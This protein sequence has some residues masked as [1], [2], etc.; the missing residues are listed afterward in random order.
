MSTNHYNRSIANRSALYVALF[1]VA[2]L[3]YLSRSIIAAP[4]DPVIA[5]FPHSYLHLSKSTNPVIALSYTLTS[6]TFQSDK[7]ATKTNIS[8]SSNYVIW[9]EDA[10]LVSRFR[11]APETNAQPTVS[12]VGVCS[13]Q[14]W[15]LNAKTQLVWNTK[16]DSKI[17]AR[18]SASEISMR[19]LAED[20]AVR[21]LH[22]GIPLIPLGSVSIEGKNL[23]ATNREGKIWSGQM[24][25]DGSNAIH[26]VLNWRGSS[27]FAIQSA[28]FFSSLTNLLPAR[29]VATLIVSENA[30]ERKTW[31]DIQFKLLNEP[32]PQAAFSPSTLISGK[33]DTY[34]RSGNKVSYI[35]NKNKLVPVTR[36]T[37]EG[38]G[39][40][41]PLMLAA[42]FIT[43]FL[44]LRGYMSFKKSSKEKAYHQ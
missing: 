38:P 34:I 39:W 18:K 41:R 17:S 37:G 35:S 36:S 29:C 23:V 31:S 11:P 44:F 21:L 8:S 7:G 1:A 2:S 10:F 42:I 40:G 27:A 4:S 12:G 9:Q 25:S 3:I 33:P 43:S 22:F 14:Y 26:A 13:N 30:V 15:T 24:S 6:E 16:S 32:L 19:Q 5:G 28:L 20:D